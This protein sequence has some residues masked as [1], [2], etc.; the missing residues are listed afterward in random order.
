MA[1][2]K[3]RTAKTSEQL[4]HELEIAKQKLAE[5]EQRA[6]AEELKDAI[7]ATNFAAQFLKVKLAAPKVS[8][9]AILQAFGVAA[10][11][12][13]VQVSQAPMQTRARKP[14]A[15]KAVTKSSKTAK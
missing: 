13:R 10:G 15:D 9:I 11:I 5:L 1:T 7:A 12:K 6:Y 14:K 2:R 8:D 3:P 4:K